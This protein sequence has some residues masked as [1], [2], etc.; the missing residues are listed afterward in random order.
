MSENELIDQTLETIQ[1]AAEQGVILDEDAKITGERTLNDG[2]KITYTIYD[3][4]D[5]SMDPYER[6]K[7]IGESWN[8]GTS[9]T[10]V[11]CI[12]FAQ[13][14]DNLHDNSESNLTHWEKIVGSNAGF[15]GFFSDN[16]LIYNVKCH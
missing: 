7:I 13:I 11:I 9:G 12:G 4:N 5:T 16:G 10:S 14:T 8:C 15:L 2:H 3:G 1:K 6:V